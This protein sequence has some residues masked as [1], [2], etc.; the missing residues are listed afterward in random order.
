MDAHLFEN[1]PLELWDITLE[2]CN[3]STL[4]TLFDYSDKFKLKII[5]NLSSL[6]PLMNQA[7]RVGNINLIRELLLKGFDYDNIGLLIAAESNQLKTLEYLFENLH[8]ELDK[9]LSEYAAGHRKLD[10]LKI[11]HKH[12]SLESNYLYPIVAGT[13]SNICLIVKN[14]V[15]LEKLQAVLDWLLESGYLMLNNRWWK[16]ARYGHLYILKYGY[17]YHKQHLDKKLYHFA[18]S[19]GH[20]DIAKWLYKHDC[21]KDEMGALTAITYDH[22]HIVEWMHEVKYPFYENIFKSVVK[23][24]NLHHIKW[25]HKHGYSRKVNTFLQRV[26]INSDVLTW[27]ID[28][29]LCSLIK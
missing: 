17:S 2:Y 20:L 23:T 19:E 24:N 16:A 7:I 21:P 29:D 28:N 9:I 14:Q 6:P 18:I 26:K 8:F 4:V 12:Y 1:I 11:I 3:D 13:M 25:L 15:I 5:A 10:V 22:I 27:L